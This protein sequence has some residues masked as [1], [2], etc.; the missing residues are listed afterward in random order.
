[1]KKLFYGLR[2]QNVDQPGG[3]TLK[4]TRTQLKRLNKLDAGK[5]ARL[6]FDKTQLKAIKGVRT[7][8]KKVVEE[9]AELSLTPMDVEKPTKVRFNDIPEVWKGDGIASLILTFIKSTSPKV[10]GTLRLAAATGAVSG[11]ANKKASGRGITRIGGSIK[12]SKNNLENMMQMGNVIDERT[13][14]K[15]KI[16]NKMNND[17]KAMN[18]GLIGTLLA[19]LPGSILPSLLSAKG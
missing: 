17:L 10:L 18:G 11:A 8:T 2:K 14:N 12:I 15:Y 9:M 3:S 16:V 5:S 7:T 13:N 4:L 1:M 19:A 6:T